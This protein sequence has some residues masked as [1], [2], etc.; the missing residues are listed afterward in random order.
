MGKKLRANSEYVNGPRGLHY[1]PGDIF[2]PSDAL[3]LFLMVDAP[4]VFDVVTPLAP[5]KS[6]DAPAKDKMLRKPK[7]KK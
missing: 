7:A 2:E 5:T 3:Y 1:R 4:G 6:V